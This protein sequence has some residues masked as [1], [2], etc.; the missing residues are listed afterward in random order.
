VL[1]PY[2]MARY[3]RLRGDGAAAVEAMRQSVPLFSRAPHARPGD[4]AAGR[5]VLEASAR[6]D[7]ASGAAAD[8]DQP[9]AWAVRLAAESFPCTAADA[10][11]AVASVTVQA[12]LPGTRTV[13]PVTRPSRVSAGGGR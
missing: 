10:V 11:A 4:P 9:G 8:Q 3:D 2:A 13:A 7:S 1:H 12:G 5:G 6:P